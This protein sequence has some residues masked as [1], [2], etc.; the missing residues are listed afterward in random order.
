MKTDIKL[1]RH[2]YWLMRKGKVK[3]FNE[4]RPIELI[5]VNAVI[6]KLNINCERLKFNLNSITIR[7]SEIYNS[8]FYNFEFFNLIFDE[9]K[10]INSKFS[11]SK[12]YNSK[13]YKSKFEDSSFYAS[14]FKDSKFKFIKFID[15]EFRDSEIIR[16]DLND[17]QFKCSVLN[18]SKFNDSK[19]NH[20]EFFESEFSDSEFSDLA[21]NNSC[22]NNSRF[23]DSKF[24]D[25]E[26]NNSRFNDSRFNL[27]FLGV[28]FNYC[29]G[30]F[31]VDQWIE[32]NLEKH[33]N[34]YIVYKRI[35]EG[36]PF[37]SPKNWKIEKNSI[38][39][40]E[41]NR[42]VTA[43]CGA[44]VNCGTKDWVLINYR[45]N[46]LWKCLIKWE[47]VHNMIVPWNT[48]GKIR[49]GKLQLLKK[50]KH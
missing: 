12:F 34:G 6:K 32:N 24:D 45:K 40:A 49:C 44:G 47:W 39:T 19:F 3:E 38:L 28:S 18:N 48:D 14:K 7:N 11:N 30:L 15:S 27:C 42:E 29:D 8:N 21:F 35:G 25:S 37:K 9:S 46:S 36:T 23:Y 41:V 31:D 5:I 16:S 4:T 26:F 33:K 20:L 10:F 2:L 1:L 17:L 22:F 43:Q 50:L 13:F